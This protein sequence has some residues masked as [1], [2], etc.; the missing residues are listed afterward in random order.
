MAAGQ[1]P[2]ALEVFTNSDWSDEV[3]FYGDTRASPVSLIGAGAQID[4]KPR[5]GSGSTAVFTLSTGNGRLVVQD[6]RI[7]I[8]V[9][10]AVMA[11]LAPGTYD[12]QLRIFWPT[13][14]DETYVVGQVVVVRGFAP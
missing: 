12:L 9:D 11:N 1:L 14:L 13:D 4:L 5:P 2:Q 6:N 7:L 8:F 3:V 10:K